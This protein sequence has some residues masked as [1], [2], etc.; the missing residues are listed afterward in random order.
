MREY[1]EVRT[2]I[3]EA[4]QPRLEMLEMGGDLADDFDFVAAGVVDSAAFVELIAEL[5]GRF[6]VEL[7]FEAVDLRDLNRVGGLA[8]AL[9][10]AGEDHG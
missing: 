2:A 8:Q 3:V 4:L 6:A 7:D 9:L 5:E 10:D 1:S